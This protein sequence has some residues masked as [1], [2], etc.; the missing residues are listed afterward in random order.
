MEKR[1]N[2][3]LKGYLTYFASLGTNETEP[4]LWWNGGKCHAEFAR[5]ANDVRLSCGGLLDVVFSHAA[6]FPARVI[7]Q[8]SLEE[9]SR[10][11]FEAAVSRGWQ[12]ASYS[13]ENRT[14]VFV[15]ADLAVTVTRAANWVDTS[16]VLDVIESYVEAEKMFQY[17]FGF[18]FLGSPTLTG[19]YGLEQALSPKIDASVLPDDFAALLH[20]NTTQGRSE[21][22]FP[23]DTKAFWFYDRRF[24]YAADCRL[25]M[26]CGVPRRE[27]GGKFVPYDPAFYR[28]VFA[29]PDNWLHVGLLPVLTPG[30]G[31]QWPIEGSHETFVAEPEL[32]LA[33]AQGWEFSVLEC[34]RFDKA[35]P[36]ENWRN[37]LVGMWEVANERGDKAEAGIYRRILL[38]AIGGLYARSYAREH[39]TTAAEFA[40]LNDDSALTAEPVES[41]GMRVTVRHERD[42]RFYMPHWAAYVWS[43]ARATLASRMLTLPVSDVL[44]CHVDAIYSREA[45]QGS[46][47][48][49]GQFRLKGKLSFG[50]PER[51]R[52][53]RDLNELAKLAEKQG[54]DR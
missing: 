38:Q 12:L 34:W 51:L 48:E 42:R 16:N 50:W 29:V 43:R 5:I 22:F 4:G 45:M 31:W 15:K 44:A 6:T 11:W 53:K 35:R 37:K 39:I 21:T 54:G 52:T 10:S 18:S 8:G 2:K 24:A 3:F 27:R 46:G 9:L 14:G 47:N 17:E 26:P 1:N 33:A 19:L 13:H 49:V 20:A 23:A 32:R 30:I 28:I 40:D 41:G 25:E 7:V 36:L